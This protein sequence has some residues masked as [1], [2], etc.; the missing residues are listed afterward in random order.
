MRY[1][2]A[3]TEFFDNKIKV[4][5]VDAENET[6]AILDSVADFLEPIDEHINQWL[7]DMRHK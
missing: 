3:I 6:M 1:A 4:I 2:V 5:I 7:I